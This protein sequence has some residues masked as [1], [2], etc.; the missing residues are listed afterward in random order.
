[1]TIAAAESEIRDLPPD[2]QSRFLH[3]AEMLEEL[4]PQNLGMPHVRSLGQKLWEMR[5]NGRD[6]IARAIYFMASDR[7]LIVVRAFV[8]K[9][10]KTPQREIRLALQ[11]MKEAED[12]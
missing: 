5:M 1:M 9:S 3:I 8:K 12:G 10:E 6:G 7:R 4:G 11:R 2:L